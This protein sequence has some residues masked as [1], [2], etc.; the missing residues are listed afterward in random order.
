MMVRLLVVAVFSLH[1]HGLGLLRGGFG[2]A[3]LDTEAQ[4]PLHNYRLSEHGRVANEKTS[5]TLLYQNNLNSSDDQNHAGAILLDP[6]GQ[7]DL[8]DACEEIGE[9]MI[10][11]STIMEYKEDFLNIFSYHF[12]VRNQT[13]KIEQ[14]R[15]YI[16][17]G[18]LIVKDGDEHF[19]HHP[20]PSRNVQLPVLCTQS[21]SGGGERRDRDAQRQLIRVNSESNTYI[22]SRDRK[23][24]RFLGIPYADSPTRFSYAKPYSGK[25]HTIE[26]TEYGP[27]CVQFAGGSENC[28]YLNIQTPYIPKK[29]STL[30][31]RPVL[32]WI[33]GGDFTAGTGSDPVTDGGNLASREDIVVVTFNY[34][35]STLGFLAVPGTDIQGNYGIADQLLALEWT[36]KHIAQ[37]GGDPRQITIMGE[38]AGAS[39]VK[40]LLSSPHARGKFQGAIA[41]SDVKDGVH[42]VHVP[43]EAPNNSYLSILELYQTT[44]Q[45]VFSE[46]RCEGTTEQ[47]ISCLRELSAF[48]LVTLPTVARHVVQD[49]KYIDTPGLDHGAEH[50]DIPVMFGNTVDE[51]ASFIQYPS[52][53]I[54]TELDGIQEPLDLSTTQA[55]RILDSNHFPSPN[56]GNITLDS[57][58]IA[59]RIATDVKVRCPNQAAIYAGVSSGKIKP[60]YYYQMQRTM[61]GVDPNNIGGPPPTPDSPNGDPQ[62]PYFRLH[63]SDLPFVFGNLDTIRDPSDLYAAQLISSYFAEFVRSG[64]PNPD[65]KYLTARGYKRTLKALRAFGPWEPVH[66]ASGPIQMLDFPSQN[67]PFQDLEQCEFLGFPDNVLA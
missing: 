3:D 14:E 5:L 18:V 35:L 26:A 41:M 58:T 11:L 56:T 37:F 55:L 20:F 64:Q 9:T 45:K 66:N 46:A 50:A 28:L 19:E 22:G 32:F 7:H 31:L 2:P 30:G 59:Q 57:F 63:G 4:A 10:S 25:F 48:T 13:E 36:I 29:N 12:Y 53:D 1:A 24:F 17:N 33:H 54:K 8:R 47:Q 62:L 21:S 15:F 40:A 43:G 16:R 67:A 42:I 52:T 61:G 60:S 39:S 38:G 49:G 44:G 6:T 65:A 23:S 34:R 51:G 27:S